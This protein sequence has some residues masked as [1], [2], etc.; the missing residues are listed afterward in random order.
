MANRSAVLALFL[1]TVLSLRLPAQSNTAEIF[2]GYS[3]AKINPESALP[4]QNAHGW[5]GSATGY[6]ISWFGAG[7]EIAAHFGDIPAPPSA[8]APSLHFKEYSYLVGPQFRFLNTE[9][10]QAGFRLLL[11][12]VFGQVNPD[13]SPTPAQAQALGPAALYCLNPTQ[14]PS[15]VSGF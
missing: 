14:L 4:K 1:F 7:M 9:K 2:G 5:V 12:G 8:S 10:T 6:A 13:S 15:P 3:Y 11:G